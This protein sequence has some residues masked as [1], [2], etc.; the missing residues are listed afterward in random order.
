MIFSVYE[1]ALSL[2]F[3]KLDYM[4]YF[5][6]EFMFYVLFFAEATDT[7]YIVNCK[8]FCISSVVV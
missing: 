6:I 1:H 7:P 3:A 4:S 8:L 5:M 2:V